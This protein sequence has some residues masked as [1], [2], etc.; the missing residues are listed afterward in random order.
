MLLIE[1]NVNILNSKQHGL[2]KVESLYVH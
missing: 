1:I 2:F